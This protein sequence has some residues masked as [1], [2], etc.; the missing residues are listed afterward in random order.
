MEIVNLEIV[1]LSVSTT[2]LCL[3]ICSHGNLLLLQIIII[4]QEFFSSN[5]NVLGN[6]TFIILANIRPAR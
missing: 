2:V 5:Q 4:I 1:I 6:G 3:T